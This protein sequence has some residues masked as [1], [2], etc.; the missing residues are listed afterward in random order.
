MER[1]KLDE[2]DFKII[3]HICSGI[4]SYDE[5]AELCNV[6]RNTVYRR[7]SKLERMGVI[8]RVVMAV[9]NFEKLNIVAVIG[10]INLN[11]QDIEKVVNILKK[12]PGIMLVCK[13]YGEHDLV[14][15][16]LCRREDVGSCILKLRKTLEDLKVQISTFDISISISWDK[17][18]FPTQ[19]EHGLEQ[20]SPSSC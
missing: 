18:E 5:L 17:L 3:R 7:V 8:T 10:G 15:I 2:L 1:E 4:H 19:F 16:L 20:R 13:T 9:P 12:H 6:G 11:F 14:F